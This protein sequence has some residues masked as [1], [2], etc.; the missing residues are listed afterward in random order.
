MA[1]GAESGDTSVLYEKKVRSS[2]PSRKAIAGQVGGLS[3]IPRDAIPDV[4]IPGFVESLLGG[5]I[6]PKL[7]FMPP[8]R[9]VQQLQIYAVLGAFV[10]GFL[11]FVV[12][13]AQGTVWHWATVGLATSLPQL[14]HFL[15][16]AVAMG[17]GVFGVFRRDMR[18]LLGSY[19]IFLLIGLRFASSKIMTSFGEF[20]AELLLEAIVV[21]YAVMLVLF[22]E[23]SSGV[24]RFSM[25]D[26]SIRTHEVYVLNVGKVRQRYLMS[27]LINPLVA[28]AVAAFALLFHRIVSWV[29]GLFDEGSALRLQESV[30]LTSVYGVA[31]GTMLIFL[32][33]GLLLA[34]NLPLRIQQ[35]QNRGLSGG[36]P[37]P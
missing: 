19:V 18:F 33:V 13:P 36:P 22:F 2:A 27:L 1:Q 16:I 24:I 28:G 7:K 31:L 6:V 9:S 14:L 20:E 4:H 12:N 30:E 37:A 32:V 29:I 11:T 34:V 23:L 5:P 3:T 15:L 8:D 17:L 35:F 10:L 21:L 26:T 25:L